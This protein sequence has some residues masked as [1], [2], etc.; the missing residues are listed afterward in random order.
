MTR[1]RPLAVAASPSGWHPAGAQ[2]QDFSAVQIKA[3]KLAD[4]FYTLEAR[5]A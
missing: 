2:Q 5:A 3:T 1:F 4:N